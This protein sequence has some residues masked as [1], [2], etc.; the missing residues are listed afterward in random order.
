MGCAIGLALL[1]PQ[2][3]SAD[4]I[5]LVE[6][7]EQYMI[8][9]DVSGQLENANWFSRDPF[10]SAY[11]DVEAGFLAAHPD[12]SQF[13]IIYT[14]WALPAPVGALYQSVANDVQGI[15]FE[16]IAPLDA[17][18]PEPYFDDTPGSQV[19]GFMHMNDWVAYLGDDPGGVDDERISLVFG[20]ELG[21]AWLSFVYYVDGGGNVRDDML[22][23]SDAHWSFYLDSGGSPVEGH[24]WV[25]NGDGTFTAIKHDIFTFSDLDL[26]LMGLMP[27]EEVQPWFILDNPSNCIDSALEDGSCAPADAH[28]FSADTYTVTASRRDITIEDVIASEGPRV[29]AF[30]DAPTEFDAS[31]LLIT[32]PGE[33]LS[34]AEKDQIDTIIERSIDIFNQQTGGR[35][36]VINRTAMPGASGDDDD[37]D[38]GDAGDD[39]DDDAADD[40]LDG[41]AGG[42]GPGGDGPGDGADG[43]GDDGSA[44]GTDGGADGGD[45]LT[46]DG[47]ACGADA[48]QNRRFPALM[49]LLGLFAVARRR[50]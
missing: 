29:P 44:D 18:I 26:Y 42:E 19:F 45:G 14:T 1:F 35:G 20:Q 48:G 6:Q 24:D 3:A 12:D 2:L 13:L 43:V 5:E 47:C 25:D 34:E 50:A 39:D 40:G 23:R 11:G 37:D 46:R 28:Q 10:L 33:E 38:A 9:E 32:R 4:P 7:R 27:P 21:H 41:T 16:H 31:F 36:E 15:G 30:G 17:I 22:G 49:L 8:F